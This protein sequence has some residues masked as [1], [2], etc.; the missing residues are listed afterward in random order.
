MCQKRMFAAARPTS[1]LRWPGLAQA[2][3]SAPFRSPE[4][5]SAYPNAGLLPDTSGA[6]WESEAI[7]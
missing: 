5:H 7:L 4:L 1:L 3:S 2:F 6:P